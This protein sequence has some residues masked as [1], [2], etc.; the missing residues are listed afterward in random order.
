[1]S[2]LGQAFSRIMPRYEFHPNQ[3][4]MYVEDLESTLGRKNTIGYPMRSICPQDDKYCNHHQQCYNMQT[5][6]HK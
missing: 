4:I 3:G 5:C 1:M 6:Y 2:N